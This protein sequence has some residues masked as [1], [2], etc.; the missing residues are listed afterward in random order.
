MR[1]RHLLA[2]DASGNERRRGAE[3]EENVGDASAAGYAVEVGD[4]DDGGYD[5]L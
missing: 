1:N 5:G 4:L 3:V 2:I